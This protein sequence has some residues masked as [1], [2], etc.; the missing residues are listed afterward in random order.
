MCSGE[1]G[2]VRSGVKLNALLSQSVSRTERFSFNCPVHIPQCGSLLVCSGEG[3]DAR[4]GSNLNALLAAYGVSCN[5]DALISIVQQGARHPKEVLVSEGLLCD[6]A[7]AAAP[8]AASAVAVSAAGPLAAA[9]LRASARAAAPRAAHGRT[10]SAAGA[11]PNLQRSGSGRH[12]AGSMPAAAAAV[13]PPPPSKL[14]YAS[15]CTLAVSDAEVGAAHPVLISGSMCNPP[16]R[17]LGERLDAGLINPNCAI[18]NL[19][20]LRT[21]TL[22]GMQRT[23][24]P[25]RRE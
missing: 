11:Q 7:G 15:G 9:L 6:A 2:D 21:G 13:A 3:G 19:S 25:C 17:P 23:D 4:S 10:A 20:Q 16:Q 12:I 5:G 1:C 18:L 8:A 14:V 22:T 24:P